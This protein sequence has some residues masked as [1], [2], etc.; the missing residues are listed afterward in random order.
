MRQCHLNNTHFYYYYYPCPT[1]RYYFARLPKFPNRFSYLTFVRMLLEPSV[2]AAGQDIRLS[3]D[4]FSGSDDTDRYPC[5]AMALEMTTLVQLADLD[6][7][8]Q[9]TRRS[10]VGS[11]R[12]SWLLMKEM[13]T[14]AS[15]AR[16]LEETMT[17]VVAAIVRCSKRW[18]RSG[19]ALR[20]MAGPAA[21]LAKLPAW[22]ASLSCHASQQAGQST[23]SVW[24]THGS[25]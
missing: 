4:H 24:P 6:L 11:S 18:S 25:S 8:R 5:S 12:S 23:E 20:K 9:C 14:T 2:V 16:Y 3:S 22:L 1:N 13:A 21:G 15:M 7:V 17:E 10:A 19:C